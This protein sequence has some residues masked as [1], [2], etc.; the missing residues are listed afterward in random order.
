[1]TQEEGHCGNML[2]IQDPSMST[3]TASKTSYI[4]FI[5]PN[6][7]VNLHYRTHFTD[8]KTQR[9]SSSSAYPVGVFLKAPSQAS[10]LLLCTYFPS[11]HIHSCDLNLILKLSLLPRSFSRVPDQSTHLLSPD[12]LLDV[13]R[14]LTF[15]V[16]NGDS[17]S[18]RSG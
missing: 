11:V 7:Y 17:R 15:Y 3:N 10:S 9:R 18:S 13:F 14:D 5:S 4:Y 8:K 1:M 6:P 2:H 12:L 16:P